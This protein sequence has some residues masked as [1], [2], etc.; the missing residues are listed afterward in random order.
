MII[1][2]NWFALLCRRSELRYVQILS[3]NTQGLNEDKEEITLAIMQQKDI[4]AYAIQAAWRCGNEISD[5]YGYY[6]I[7][8]GS[9]S[10]PSKGSLSGG[11]AI[12]LSPDAVR[13]WLN[14][15]LDL[16]YCTSVIAYLL[17]SLKWRTS[18]ANQSLS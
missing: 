14:L 12:I 13:A 5:I 18:L 9:D 1:Q 15:K 16:V 3:Q 4:F 2:T 8:H 6:I 7:Q 11:V 17:S 10:K